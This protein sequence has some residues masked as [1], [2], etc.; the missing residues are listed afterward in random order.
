MDDEPITS[1]N[2]KQKLIIYQ[3]K[4]DIMEDRDCKKKAHNNQ[5]VEN[6]CTFIKRNKK[7]LHLN[8]DNTQLSESMLFKI[9]SSLTR[10][11]SLLVLHASGNPGITQELRDMAWRRIRAINPHIEKNKVEPAGC[12]K[13]EDWRTAMSVH[14]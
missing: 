2:F 11:T 3:I 5:I 6:L 7:L 12:E 1:E 8:L 14:P 10:A 9:S 4:L 13:K